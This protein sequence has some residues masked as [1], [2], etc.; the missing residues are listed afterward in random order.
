MSNVTVDSL[1]KI[2]ALCMSTCKNNLVEPVLLEDPGF[3]WIFKAG[4]TR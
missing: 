1:F 2:Y 3:N 4:L